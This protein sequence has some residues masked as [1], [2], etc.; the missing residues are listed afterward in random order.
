MTAQYEFRKMIAQVCIMGGVLVVI[1]IFSR[2]LSGNHYMARVPLGNPDLGIGD[3]RYTIESD[4]KAELTDAEIHDGVLYLDLRAEE[5][6]H[7]SVE[8]VDE[9]GRVIKCNEYTVGRGMTVFEEETG[10][11]TGDS[12]VAGA[13]SVFFLA[14]A[15]LMMRF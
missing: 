12:F 14:T 13:L 10:N 6:G 7:C 9:K 4:N 1:C 11:F 3:I 2:M 8:V 15:A 5:A